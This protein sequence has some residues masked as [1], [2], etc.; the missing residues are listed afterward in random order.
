M[1]LGVVAHAAILVLGRLGLRKAR[2]AAIVVSV[3]DQ[4]AALGRKVYFSLQFQVIVHHGEIGIARTSHDWSHH[5]HRRAERNDRTYA[6]LLL[7]ASAQFLPH[8]HSSGPAAWE[9]VPP[10]VGWV[11]PHQL[12]ASSVQTQCR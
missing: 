2:L 9:M 5:T 1:G 12:T 3:A 10:T 6:A 8:S 7:S 4:K 11:F